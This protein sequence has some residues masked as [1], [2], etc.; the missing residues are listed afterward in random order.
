MNDE[1]WNNLIDSLET[2]F[3]GLEKSVINKKELSFA[4]KEIITTVEQIIFDSPMG[5]MKIERTT[6][7]AILDKKIHY[8]HTSNSRGNTEYIY[9][10][11]E[12][13]HQVKLYKKMPGEN[14][15]QEIET[16]KGFLF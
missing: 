16:G 11:T 5:K 1:K 12:K 9:S 2:K 3:G 14:D 7:P 10:E 15:W 13:S 8:S 4:G 6:R